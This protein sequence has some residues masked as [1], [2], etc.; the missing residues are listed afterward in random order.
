MKRPAKLLFGYTWVGW[1][2]RLVLQWLFIRLYY[3]QHWG[4]LTRVVPLT[5]WG[6]AYKF[7][8]GGKIGNR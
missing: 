5:G 4:F 2:N 6:T 1:L 8:G 3:G 7:I